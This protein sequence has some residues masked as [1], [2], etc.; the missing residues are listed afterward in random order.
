MGGAL[1]TAQTLVLQN[2]YLN[3]IFYES[4]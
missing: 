1:R 4:S 2:V 3:T